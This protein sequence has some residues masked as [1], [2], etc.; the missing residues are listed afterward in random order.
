MERK[1]VITEDGSSS[2]YLP[3]WNESYHSK[4]GAIQEA[5]HV[6]IRNGLDTFEDEA[7]VAILEI[8]FG[9][10][11]NCFIAYLEAQ[12]RKLLI[13]YVGVEAYPVLIKESEQLNY[14]D[15]L[16]VDEQ[17]EIFR[18]IH[19]V[20]WDKMHKFDNHFT[21]HKRKQFFQDITDVNKFDLIFFDAFGP[22][23]Q[24]DLWTEEM[25][26]KMIQALNPNG[27]LLTYSAKGSV[28]RA[29]IEVGFTV[30]R[31]PGPPGKR[32]MLRARK[33]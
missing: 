6:F 3:E 13:N 33:N 11:L 22:R 1:V 21:L 26:A 9:T 5:Y 10:G 4:H 12:K 20:S 29:M 2:I 24:P 8:G 15:K 30:E 16:G 28:R 32:E 25:F 31:L 18:S 27:M 14:V 17:K 7:G 19:D 23:V